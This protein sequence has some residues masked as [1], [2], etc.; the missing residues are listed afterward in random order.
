MSV[1]FPCLAENKNANSRLFVACLKVFFLALSIFPFLVAFQ[2]F[3][4]EKRAIFCLFIACLKNQHSARETKSSVEFETLASAGVFDF[5][6]ISPLGTL[7]DGD[8]FVKHG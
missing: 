5:K 4:K 1:Y 6:P 2:P 8:F 3:W 7:P